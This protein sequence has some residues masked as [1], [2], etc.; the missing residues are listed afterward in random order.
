MKE[1]K[2]LLRVKTINYYSKNQSIML[3]HFVRRINAITSKII[4]IG[5]SFTMRFCVLSYEGFLCFVMRR[6]RF[7]F[8]S[9]FKSNFQRTSQINVFGTYLHKF[10]VDSP[11]T[12]ETLNLSKAF[13]CSIQKRMCNVKFN[14]EP[15]TK[16]WSVNE[17]KIV[18]KTISARCLKPLVF[19]SL[20]L[21][22]HSLNS[23]LKIIS[24]I[25]LAIVL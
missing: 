2:S 16:H 8:C 9:I 24:R 12:V 7:N 15:V 23:D 22:L 20:T 14:A 13:V 21:V 18:A 17:L 5:T 1:V 10:L 25:F 3:F 19:Y 4:D 6:L 11:S